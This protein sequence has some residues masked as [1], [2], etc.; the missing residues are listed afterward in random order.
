[1]GNLLSLSQKNLK[2]FHTV[3]GS[4]NSYR[5]RK[6]ILDPSAKTWTPKD[7]KMSFALDG[8]LALNG[9][10]DYFFD[11]DSGSQ[12]KPSAGS[13]WKGVDAARTW[14]DRHENRFNILNRGSM[15]KAEKYMKIMMYAVFAAVGGIV[16]VIVLMMQKM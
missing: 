14:R 13:G 9:G 1:M 3:S 11:M 7:S 4:T 5:K 2:V 10:R 16:G 8:S 15:E 12:F 6:V